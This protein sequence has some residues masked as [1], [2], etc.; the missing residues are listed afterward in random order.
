MPK[1]CALASDGSWAK[2][3]FDCQACGKGSSGKYIGVTTN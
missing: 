2:F 1:Y 3:T